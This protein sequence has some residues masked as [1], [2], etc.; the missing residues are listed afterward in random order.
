[1]EMLRMH[2]MLLQ[3]R[4]H[5]RFVEYKKG[6][7]PIVEHQMLHRKEIDTSW[8]SDA[9]FLLLRLSWFMESGLWIMA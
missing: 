7:V 2:V 5:D 3:E 9:Q 4:G 6:M 8:F 1:M